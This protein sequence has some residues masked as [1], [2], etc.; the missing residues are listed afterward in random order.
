MIKVLIVDDSI[1]MRNMISD[2]MKTEH[3]IKIVGKAKNG[4][5]AVRMNSELSPDVIT[6]DVEMP[7]MDGITALKKIMKEKPTKIIMV[8]S[9]TYEGTAETLESLSN[10]AY[11]FIAKPSGRVSFDI[12]KIKESLIK[13]IKDSQYVNLKALREDRK[14][15]NKVEK[16]KLSKFIR[17]QRNYSRTEKKVIA[18]GISTGGPKALQRVIPQLPIDID[19]GI[20]IVQ[21]MPPKFTKS[22][23]DRLDILSNIRVKE[24]AEGDKIENGL[25]LIAPGNYHI[26][27]YQKGNDKYIKLDSSPPYTG[28]RPSANVLF[29]SVAQNYG[30]NAIGVIMTGM[31]SDGAEH[32][33]TLKDTGARTIAQNEK[34]CVVYGMPRVAIEM[35]AVDYIEDL[36]NISERIISILNNNN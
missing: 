18:I 4:E 11:D 9:L 31:G 34:S 10:G 17:K 13:K 19:A 33:K 6:L 36:D 30:E 24:A 15:L 26:I 21:H 32:L 3:D 7:V 8:S 28:H 20:L 29:R 35:D 22:L 23:A 27:I 2:M 5:E 14:P 12:K 25:A 1:F 16:P